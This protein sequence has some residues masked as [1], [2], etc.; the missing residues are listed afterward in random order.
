[1]TQFLTICE[2][3][4]M[5]FI[6]MRESITT[7]SPKK[8]GDY[9]DVLT[10]SKGPKRKSLEFKKRV[11]ARKSL[12]LLQKHIATHGLYFLMIAPILK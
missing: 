4:L 8:S 6:Y 2:Y 11:T 3:T 12:L 10:T 5:F 1:M 9:F 7:L